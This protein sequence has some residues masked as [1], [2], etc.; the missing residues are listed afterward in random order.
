MRTPLALL[1]IAAAA[2]GP[3]AA[4]SAKEIASV[5]VCGADGCHDVTARATHA[6]LDGGPPTTAPDVAAPYYR[7]K[8]K[9]RVEGGEAV[10]GWTNLWI[11][12][13]ELLRGDD[14]AWMT[15]AST[16]VDALKLLAR[17]VEPLAAE[18]LTLPAPEGAP[19]R[20][21]APDDGGLPTVVWAFI[22]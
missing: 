14:G 15:P 22:V 8:V 10:A 6:V 16:T 4:A 18:G 9:M 21:P 5:K 19:A 11:P 3:A 2:L 13:A 12:S 17:G 7:I 1:A 20:A